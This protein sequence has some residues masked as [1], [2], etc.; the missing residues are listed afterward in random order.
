MEKKEQLG[1]EN[2]RM[3]PLLEGQDYVDFLNGIDLSFISQDEKADKIF[4]PSKLFKTLSCGSPVLC[5]AG[6]GSELAS[7]ILKARAGAVFDFDE[8]E[9]IISFL[10]LLTEDKHKLNE[11]GMNAYNFARLEYDKSAIIE[12]FLTD[13]EARNSN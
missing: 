2:V 8:H 11:L 6:K 1:I 12:N 7:I 3:M 13:I 9:R 4:I 10:S 5:V